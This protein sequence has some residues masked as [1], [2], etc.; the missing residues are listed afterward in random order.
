MQDGFRIKGARVKINSKSHLHQGQ[1]GTV[2]KD[3]GNTVL[4]KADNEK[5]KDAYKSRV[6]SNKE[7]IDPKSYLPGKFFM[8]LPITLIE[9]SS[10]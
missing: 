6:G 10:K 2:V 1:K 9:I 7:G 5:H 3:Y 8:A 4:I